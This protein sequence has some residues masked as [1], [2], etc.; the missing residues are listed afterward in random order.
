MVSVTS[1]CL[2]PV[3]ASC[4]S[5]AFNEEDRNLSVVE[6]S[7]AAPEK[8]AGITLCASE[9]KVEFDHRRKKVIPSSTN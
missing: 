1:D 4:L 3:Q 8:A 6:S 5:I 9:V 7:H 2:L